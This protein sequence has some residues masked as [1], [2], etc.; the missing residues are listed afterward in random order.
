MHKFLFK[1]V[2]SHA[3]NEVLTQRRRNDGKLFPDALGSIAM[4]EDRQ[5]EFMR[6]YQ[7][8][9]EKKLKENEREVLEYWKAQLDKLLAMKPEGVAS[10]Q[11]QIKRISDM[12]LNRIR[13]LKKD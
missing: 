3:A 1:L 7:A 4:S 2:A 13:I 10:L 9:F 5:E 6:Q 11:L 8:R 12:M